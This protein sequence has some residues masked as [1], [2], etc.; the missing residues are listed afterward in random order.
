[1]KIVKQTT[2]MSMLEYDVYTWDFERKQWKTV[3]EK[4]TFSSHVQAAKRQI[5]L[6]KT[7]HHDRV[8]KNMDIHPTWVTK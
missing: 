5:A 7:E 2:M 1:M 3:H 4:E 8:I 6:L